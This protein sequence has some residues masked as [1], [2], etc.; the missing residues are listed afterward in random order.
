MSCCHSDGP[1]L[2]SLLAWR[3]ICS[4]ATPLL[5]AFS[6][7]YHIPSSLIC[8]LILF[9]HLYFDLTHFTHLFLIFASISHLFFESLS[10]RKW[11]CQLRGSILVSPSLFPVPTFPRVP[12]VLFHLVLF[13]AGF[14]GSSWRIKSRPLRGDP[15]RT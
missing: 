12:S 3:E 1:L 9:F 11:F 4:V 7:V 10:F 13:S 14:S 5:C 2:Q 15:S 8:L 6:S